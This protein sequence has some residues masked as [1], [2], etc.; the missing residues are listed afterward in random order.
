MAIEDNASIALI[1][2]GYK[3][4]KLYSVIPDTGNGDFTFSRGSTATRV[5]AAGLIET[6]PIDVPRLDYPLIDGV[7]QSCPALLLEP[8]RLN[9]AT[10]SEDFYSWSNGTAYVTRDQATAPDGN[11]SADL[12]AKTTS[13]QNISKTLTVTSGSDYSFS[14]FVKA[15]TISGITLRLASGTYDVRKY[16]NLEDLSVSNAGGNQTGFVGSKV[17]KY[18]NGWYRYTI[19]AT[20]NATTQYLNIYVGNGTVAESG[21]IYIWG[22]QFEL[23]DYPTSYIPNLSSGTT[24]RNADECKGAGTTAEFNDSEGVLFAELEAFE[25]GGTARYIG[26]TDGGG[27]PYTNSVT[28]QYRNDGNLRVF[29]NGL[30]FADAICI[31]GID[32]TVN[33][34]IAVRYK[35]NDMA[36]YVDGIAQSLSGS[37]VYQT[38]SG[39]NELTFAQP[40][41]LYVNP[42]YGKSR[43]LMTFKIGLTDS[44]LEKISSWTSFSEMAKGQLYTIE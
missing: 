3:S 38:I 7:V 43:Q 1:P 36:V 28:I 14:V 20:S 44:E 13:F 39:L 9:L 19:T 34:K 21:N 11:T 24:T 25:D 33:H 16:L 10:Y 30:D 40:S 32:Q 42:F 2:S 35:Q 31:V 22:A 18:P 27:S 12:F 5:N 37:F 8:Q 29:H 26:L 17:E 4:G 6:M 41:Y 15:N 23:G